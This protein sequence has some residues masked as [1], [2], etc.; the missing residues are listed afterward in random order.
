MDFSLESLVTKLEHVQIALEVASANIP[1]AKL[2]NAVETMRDLVAQFVGPCIE[3]ESMATAFSELI[4]KLEEKLATKEDEVDK[5]RSIIFDLNENNKPVN[6]NIQEDLSLGN[7]IPTYISEQLTMQSIELQQYKELYSNSSNE[8]LL[9]TLTDTLLTEI[10]SL[11]STLEKKEAELNSC[12]LDKELVEQ[13][14]DFLALKIVDLVEE[15]R[16]QRSQLTLVNN[17][18]MQIILSVKKLQTMF[19][20]N[21]KLN[22]STDEVVALQYVNSVVNEML[23]LRK[24]I[25]FT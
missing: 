11:K 19:S 13:E 21:L 24:R 25:E 16:I 17:V 12:I 10:D 7:I 22:G 5:L 9:E 4:V 8:D 18:L 23:E 15:T 20:L 3:T 1:D 6:P 2:H 14:A